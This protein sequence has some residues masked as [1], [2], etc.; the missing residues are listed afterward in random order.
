MVE[1]KNRSGESINCIIE[2]STHVTLSVANNTALKCVFSNQTSDL[3]IALTCPPVPS[4]PPTPTITR[5]GI[6]YVPDTNR[7]I[8]PYTFAGPRVT[9][10]PSW[11][12][13]VVQDTLYVHLTLSSGSWFV[14]ITPS[15]SEGK[16]I[17]SATYL[18]H[19][20]ESKKKATPKRASHNLSAVR[21]MSDDADFH[22]ECLDNV[23]IPVHSL[24]LKTYWPFFKTMMQNDCAESNDKVLK[25]DYPADWIEVLVSFIYSQDVQM[26]FEQATGL[27]VVAEMYQLSEL[28]DMAT[29]E[30]L[31]CAKDSI[32][33]EAALTGW[34][35]AFQAQNEKATAFLAGQ[36]ASK[37]SQFGQSDGEK[38][39]FSDLSAEEALGLYFDTLK[40]STLKK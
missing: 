39:A 32:T 37:Q 5:T 2:N 10:E 21:N 15:P 36:V 20:Y 18:K 11:K 23:R 3:T 22:I 29:D 8:A 12:Y 25:L 24:I 33:L 31:G 4:T 26:S 34:V 40:I 7:V 27:L 14:M 38:A 28:T 35:R 16:L 17:T 1:E 19:L 13:Y 9:R 30:I 6:T